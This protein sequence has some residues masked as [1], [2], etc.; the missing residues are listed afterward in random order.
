M[1]IKRLILTLL[2]ILATNGFATVAEKTKDHLRHRCFVWTPT[3]ECKAK[4]SDDDERLVR[5]LTAKL[6]VADATDKVLA[7]GKEAL[8]HDGDP[9]TALYRYNQ[10]LILDATRAEG[11]KGAADSFLSMEMSPE[12]LPLA[13]KAVELDSKNGEA[14]VT[15][16]RAELTFD[17]K[18]AKTNYQKGISLGAVPSADLAKALGIESKLPKSPSPN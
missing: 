9:V 10:A 4:H 2:P 17:K 18:Q 11:W 3:V 6:S 16:A 12:A 13:K 7:D 15:L 8:L 1:R 14:F 5:H